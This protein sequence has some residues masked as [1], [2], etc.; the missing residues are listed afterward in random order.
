MRTM[1]YLDFDW[2]YCSKFQDAFIFDSSKSLKEPEKSD[3]SDNWQRVQLPHTNIKLSN[4][5]FDDRAF[6]FVS[7][8]RRVL[9]LPECKNKLQFVLLRFE[10]VMN[11]AE[12]YLNGKLITSHKGGYT[13]FEVLL[14]ENQMHSD[15]E[16]ELFV[17]VDSTERNDTPPFGN[18][19]DYL[20]YG[21]IYREVSLHICDALRFTHVKLTP[22]IQDPEF[23]QNRDSLI[24]GHINL[25]VEIAN[26]LGLQGAQQLQL[27]CCNKNQNY[28]LEL[29]GATTQSFIIESSQF[30]NLKLWDIN[31]GN[32]YEV[33]LQLNDMDYYHDRI[34]WRN[35]RFTPEGFWINGRYE[36]LIGL[37]RHQSYPY[38]GYAMPANAQE[39]DADLFL[40]YGCNILRTSHYVQHREFIKHCDE[41]GLLVF[42]EI[43]G[44][45]YIGDSTEWQEQVLA[46]VRD[47]I[48]RD[49]NSPSIV[50]WGVRI[51]ESFD[52][53][54]LYSKTNALAH[55]LD[56][57]RQTGGV[58]CHPNSELLEDVYTMNNFVLGGSLNKCPVALNGQH[59][60]TGLEQAVPYLTTESN[61]H[62][63][64]TKAWDP[65]ERRIE[66]AIRHLRVIEAA[67]S[68]QLHSGS[69]SWCA[70]DYNTH[71]EFGAGDKICHH[72]VFDMYRQPKFAA[73]AYRSQK[74]PK[75]EIILEPLT[76][77]ALGERDKGQLGPLWIL[78][79]CDYISLYI[80]KK[81]RPVNGSAKIF[82]AR[83]IFKGLPHPPS[84]IWEVA[85]VWGNSFEDAEFKGFIDGKEVF[86]KEFSANP[87][88]SNLQWT[89]DQKQ[90]SIQRPEATR[91]SIQV[92]DQLEN[93]L[94]FIFGM[95][96]LH[97]KGPQ[98]QIYADEVQTTMESE[99]TEVQKVFATI[100][101]GSTAIW[102]ISCGEQGRVEINAQMLGYP[103]LQAN[104][105]LYID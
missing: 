68:T 94:P 95:L 55:Q 4:S 38:A 71:H 46:D 14:P 101:G 23:I 61:G 33:Q 73:W 91:L 24:S 5:Y 26:P 63:F 7:A 74:D 53:H 72:G 6:T 69:I 70:F 28:T 50:L 37:N 75:Q 39:K 103:Q 44:W 9:H 49:Y 42:T 12:I 43:P 64:P 80:N 13:P 8:Y 65:E 47:M 81:E 78:H 83:G 87:V 36:K 27:D 79:N 40:E 93:S 60:I 52:H 58:R 1:E 56:P 31:Q 59:E 34:G 51:N 99:D 3:K 88:A 67:Y 19:I 104:I 22:V 77:W 48:L 21:G 86:S 41:I 102:L 92:V 18:L 29:T 62:M 10:G 100:R 96:C 15:S 90:L 82:P 54:E 89:V 11:Y 97:I 25:E 84:V 57:T 76:C 30:D 16:N 2:Y 20:T 35:C 85:N 32:L 66:H 98:V 17:K 45:G 105:E